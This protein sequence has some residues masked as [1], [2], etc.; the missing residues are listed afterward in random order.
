MRYGPLTLPEF[1]GG[2]GLGGRDS[3]D[4][5]Q[6]R[7]DR[8]RVGRSRPSTRSGRN[9]SSRLRVFVQRCCLPLS[10]LIRERACGIRRITSME[11]EVGQHPDGRTVRKGPDWRAGLVSVV[12]EERTSGLAGRWLLASRGSKGEI[13]RESVERG[14]NEKA[15]IDTRCPDA[16]PSEGTRMTRMTSQH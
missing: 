15:L 12:M 6:R 7:R 14:W 1:E 9:I 2:L 13:E 11:P 3:S 16:I 5:R 10:Q 4:W 8:R